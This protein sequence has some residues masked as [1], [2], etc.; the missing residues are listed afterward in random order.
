MLKITDD[1]NHDHLWKVVR[2]QN[3]S[4]LRV[5]IYTKGDFQNIFDQ[6]ALTYNSANP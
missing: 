5:R 6:A 3:K 4:I 2:K 1:Y